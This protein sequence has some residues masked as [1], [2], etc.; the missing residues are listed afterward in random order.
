MAA[1]IFALLDDVAVLADDVAVNTKIATAKTAGIL[2]DDLALNAEKATGFEQ[3]RELAV[4]WAITKGSLLNKVILLP[5][6][7]LLSAF[8]P[9]IIPYI[10]I[11]GGL[12]L[13]YE[14][15]EKIG[16]YFGFISDHSEDHK[17]KLKN[18]TKE[19]ILDIEKKKIKDAIRTD[20]V[21]SIEIVVLILGTV[22]TQPLLVQIAVTMLVSFIATLGVYG[23]VAMIV[24]IDNIGFWLISKGKVESGNFLVALMP[25]IIKV[26]SVIGTIAMILVGGGILSHNIEFI[27]HLHIESIPVI[28]NELVVGI[29]VGSVVL[30]LVNIYKKLQG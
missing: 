5:I 8:A 3:H 1:G 11:V 12:Y 4:I 26:L 10:L 20:F 23:V 15:A 18:S 6:A 27:H 24:R 30:I 25:K 29:V 22:L 28:L 7:F 19:N 21:L 14:G 2:G 16:E 17:D 9:W 13:L